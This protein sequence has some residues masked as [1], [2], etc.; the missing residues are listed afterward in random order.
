MKRREFGSGSTAIDL[1]HIN[2]TENKDSKEKSGRLSIPRISPSYN[3]I[4]ALKPLGTELVARLGEES[5]PL[6]DIFI[7]NPIVTQKSADALTALRQQEDK[8]PAIIR[9]LGGVSEQPEVGKTAFPS[10]RH[11]M[12][13][14]VL[15]V[16]GAFGTLVEA[17]G[18]NKHEN[19]LYNDTYQYITEVE[20]LEAAYTA[21][22][23]KRR[24]IR[25][26][27][28]TLKVITP[29]YFGG[30]EVKITQ[31]TMDGYQE[32]ATK[33]VERYIKQYSPAV[34]EPQSA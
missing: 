18:R 2:A 26:G 20:D 16:L 7:N 14:R 33:A 25:L 17:E 3:E 22:T 21:E 15:D 29:K 11:I 23:S 1:I 8:N 30:E 13:N 4:Q 31:K 28:P 34:A 9:L 12:H 10:S 24:I 27:E 6:V 32:F 5:K 19:G